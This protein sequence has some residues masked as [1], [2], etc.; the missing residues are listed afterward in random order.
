[1]DDDCITYKGVIYYP[2][3]NLAPLTS[4]VETCPGCGGEGEM[5]GR[6]CTTCRGKGLIFPPLRA[7]PGEAVSQSNAEPRKE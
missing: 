7:A 6:D 2:A 1:M 4:G 3:K 5:Y